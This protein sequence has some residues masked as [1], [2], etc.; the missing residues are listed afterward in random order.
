ME[1]KLAYTIKKQKGRWRVVGDEV[2]DRG[3]TMQG[4]W[5]VEISVSFILSAMGSH[6]R[7]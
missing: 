3:P 7:F 5:A 4:L 1:N 6:R 2:G